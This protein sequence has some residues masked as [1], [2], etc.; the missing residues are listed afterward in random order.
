MHDT[1]FVGREVRK[2]R[3]KK[4]E[5]NANWMVKRVKSWNAC[6]TLIKKWSILKEKDKNEP[7]NGPKR[8]TENRLGT[9]ACTYMFAFD[10]L[11]ILNRAK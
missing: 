6:G 5:Q 4:D 10:N 7:K 1:I 9:V 3:T 8:V 2:G 11:G